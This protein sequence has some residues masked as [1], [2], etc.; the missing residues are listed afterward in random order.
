MKL[1]LDENIGSEVERFL[2]ESGHDVKRTASG[3]ENG[4]VMHAASIEKRVLLTQDI[5][6]SNILMYPPHRH[7]GI[8]RIRIHPPSPDKSIS[9]LKRLFDKVAPGEF[10]KKLYVLEE[11]DFRVR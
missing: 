8:I 9:A 1:L 3:S 4:E 10:N 2:V 6:F 5:H 7:C 11:D